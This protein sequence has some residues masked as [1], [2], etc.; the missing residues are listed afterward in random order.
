MPYEQRVD[1]AL[2]KI[3]ASQA[4]STPQRQW[5]ERIGKQMKAELVVDR[6]ALD[7]G[8]FRNQGGFARL[9]KV[10][11]GKLEQLLSTLHD[12]LWKDVG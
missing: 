8:E 12:E 9:N 4:W 7:R 1:R 3:L 11:D 2:A 5:L 6:E 10:F